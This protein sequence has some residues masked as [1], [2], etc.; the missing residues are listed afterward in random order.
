VIVEPA[1]SLD[2]PDNVDN[3][4][5]AA[6]AVGMTSPDDVL[7]IVRDTLDT[8]DSLLPDNVDDTE[9]SLLTAALLLPDDVDNNALSLNDALLLL[10]AAL[11]FPEEDDV[12]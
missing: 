10:I 6:D 9:L 1:L 5:A 4:D 8:I 7:P 2:C 12:L 3:L 11:V